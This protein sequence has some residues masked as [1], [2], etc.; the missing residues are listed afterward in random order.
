M[1]SLSAT[2]SALK[3]QLCNRPVEIH[4]L[5]LGSQTTEDA[6]TYHFVNFYKTLNFFTYITHTA[7][8][9]TPLGI[10]RTAVKRTSRNEI[11]RVS[12]KVDNIDKA[13]SSYAA[14][15]DFRNKR[16]VT[17]LIF[18]DHLTSYLDAKVVFDGFIQSINFDRKNM[19]V[20]CTPVIGSLDFETGW[21]YQIQC[22]A[23]FG[24][25]YCKVNKALAT[26]CLSGV[27]TGGT[28]STVIDTSHLV[29]AND[30]WNWGMITFNSGLNTGCSRKIL[31]YD[32]ATATLTL[33]YALDNAVV[34]GDEY[35][36]YRGCDKTL[37]MCQNTYKNE[38]NYHG[39]HAIPL[40]ST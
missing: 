4:D 17:R 5:Y 22:N 18:R 39:F 27:A 14:D 1:Y 25:T 30:Y 3:D 32:L 37:A 40:N 13:M 36:I 20:T 2:L 11:E 19:N 16:I 35:I 21:P 12:Y 7:Q 24:G 10:S 8:A 15:H 31:D 26:N 28:S 33:D 38:M 6:Q 23:R 34:A 29:Q 9:F